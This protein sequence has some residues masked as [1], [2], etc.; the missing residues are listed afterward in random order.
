MFL[1]FGG[2]VFA[3]GNVWLGFGGLLVVWPHIFVAVT[4][5]NAEFSGTSHLEFHH[6]AVAGGIHGKMMGGI[7]PEEPRSYHGKIGPLKIVPYIYIYC[8]LATIW[9][10]DFLHGF[11]GKGIRIAGRPFDLTLLMLE[12]GDNSMHFPENIWLSVSGRSFFFR[13]SCDSGGWIFLQSNT[14]SD[15]PPDVPDFYL[16]C[17][18][19]AKVA[20]AVRWFA[21]Q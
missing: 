20:N 21:L 4:G 1:N 2:R 15:S 5:G 7:P 14:S 8:P 13:N 3:H 17:S 18:S 19:M 12:G 9:P 11:S 16:N 10:T 6:Q